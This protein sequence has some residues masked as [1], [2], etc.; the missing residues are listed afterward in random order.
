M[1]YDDDDNPQV[2]HVNGTSP[3]PLQA[4]ASSSTIVGSTPINGDDNSKTGEPSSIPEVEDGTVEDA[5]KHRRTGTDPDAQEM[6]IS[7]LKSQ[8]QDLFSQVNELN[9][10]LVK[11]YDR[12]SDLEDDIHMASSNLRSSSL[13]ISQLELERTQHLAALNT[14][15]LV[16]KAHVTAE[17]NR[18]M[19]KATEEAAQRGQAETA[20]HAIE[21]D[22]E[23]L[24][25]T[26]FGQ[27]NTMVAEARYAAHL[28]ERKVGDAERALKDAEEM[29][30]MMQTQMQSM[31]AGK[32][33]A[34]QKMKEMQELMGK[35]KWRERSSRLGTTDLIRQPKLLSS[36]LP[37]QEFLL[38]V[39]HIRSLHQTSP[40][41]PAMA[42]LLP[43]PFLARLTTEDA[44]PTVRL[45]LAPALNWLS[46]RSV[47]AA[48][49]SGQLTIEPIPVSALFSESTL[50]S[51]PT[52]VAGI[53]PN[54]DTVSCALCGMT[55][56]AATEHAQH[57]RRPPTVTGTG[58][59]SWSG[60][61]FKKT[62]N[63]LTSRP[64]SP[65]SSVIALPLST[66]SSQSGTSQAQQ[67]FIFRV[68]SAPSTTST[69][70]SALPIP[71]I[72]K[73]LSQS[74]PTPAASPN[75]HASPASS[76]PNNQPMTIYPLCS[77]G[78][79]LTRLRTTCQ[80]WSFVRTGIVEKVWEEEIPFVPPPPSPVAVLAA[81]EKPP[82]PP[83]K[84][85]LWG[86]AS[87]IGER[88]ANWGDTDKKTSTP[89]V[90][91]PSPTSTNA[92][93]PLPPRKESRRMPP[94]LPPTK[95]ESPGPSP[96]Q[97][98]TSPP[99]PQTPPR[100]GPPP[101]PRRSEVRSRASVASPSAEGD[102][103]AHTPVSAPST[104]TRVVFDA[105]FPQSP[106]RPKDRELPSE[107]TAS[108]DA[109]HGL[110]S[111][112]SAS[113][114]LPEPTPP[115]VNITSSAKLPSEV[116]LPESRPT[117]PEAPA[118]VASP[119]IASV[120][121]GAAAIATPPPL[122][123]RAPARRAVPAP[124]GVEGAGSRPGTPSP[125][126][127]E[128]VAELG[129]KL[130]KGG[131]AEGPADGEEKKSG[132]EKEKEGEKG[133]EVEKEAG[134][135]KEEEKESKEH[136]SSDPLSSDDEFVDAPVAA[137][138][139]GD[140]EYINS[141]VPSIVTTATSVPDLNGSKVV[142]EKQ[143]FETVKDAEG[144]LSQEEINATTTVTGIDIDTQSPTA[145]TDPKGTD[146]GKGDESDAEDDS[147]SKESYIGDATW[148]ERTWK[149]LARLK[150]DMFWARIGARR[151]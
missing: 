2:V 17:L 97:L 105:G 16:E 132:S 112:P 63:S 92:P 133:R 40:S 10:K 116:P 75:T 150:E 67:V 94:P 69:I 91:A 121:N 128:N 145:L 15:L 137:T 131:G 146:E 136:A 80:L 84:R 106:M 139:N 21:K 95:A 79:C 54:N 130:V 72:T 104:P 85:G 36:H 25:A 114:A 64:P 143:S 122:P 20:R 113:T 50:Y 141:E 7:S 56:V 107:S 144:A 42:T 28:S 100:N 8:I 43:L 127:Q 14:G 22:L 124:P 148:E 78:W 13:R 4:D 71:G 118:R 41:I 77:S 29:V 96:S 101:L 44:E 151:S 103:G 83:R 5:P 88:A 27:A 109:T 129:G 48:I 59:N 70:S 125:L 87:A 102:E 135:A 123:R 117:S 81:P 120:V 26:L 18:L 24:S 74:S 47:L 147:N 76:S 140:T 12:V 65:T 6:V 108:V 134:D 30:G 61:F 9:N 90:G 111:P 110:L 93:P 68:A 33:D 52:T 3:P 60:S 38:F 23:D 34:E 62:T 82:I 1:P 46:R 142:K 138:P 86:L 115:S 119:A 32:E 126:Q 99:A 53:N 45:D 31:Q 66:S 51:S 37:Y 35:G 89:A 39:A 149:E 11:S 57:R 98:P 19:E 49:H 73:S 55:I 58:R